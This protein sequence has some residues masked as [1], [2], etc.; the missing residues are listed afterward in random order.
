MGIRT[1]DKKWIEGSDGR[2]EAYDLV[3]DPEERSNLFNGSGV[4]AGFGPLAVALAARRA[5]SRAFQRAAP[6]LSEETL[7]GLR[8]LGYIR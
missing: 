2:H 1:A 6:K 8:S 3:S 4:P 7:E 5:S